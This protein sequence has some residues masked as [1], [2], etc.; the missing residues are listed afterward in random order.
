MPVQV[1]FKTALRLFRGILSFAW[2]WKV[3]YRGVCPP[4]PNRKISKIIYK[5]PIV[6][7]HLGK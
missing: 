3:H 5:F 4:L 1:I 2:F 7:I 6:V